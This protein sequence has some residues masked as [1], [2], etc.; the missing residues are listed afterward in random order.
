M[1]ERCNTKTSLSY[2]HYGG[3]GISVCEEWRE[4][5]NFRDWSYANGYSESLTIDRI[6]VNANYE[7]SNCKWS[8]RKEQARN[9]TRTAYCQ[10]NGETYCVAELAEKFNAPYKVVYQRF[11]KGI[12]PIPPEFL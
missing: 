6:D 1:N 4:Y 8:T 2:K 9:T 11:R 10:F 7:P 5:I 3:R 12:C